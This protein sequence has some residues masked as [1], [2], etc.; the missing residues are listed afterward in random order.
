MAL[1]DPM[2]ILLVSL[3]FWLRYH[4]LPDFWARFPS[5]SP[6][7]FQAGTSIPMTSTPLPDSGPFMQLWWFAYVFN[8]DLHQLR[9]IQSLQLKVEVW[10]SCSLKKEKGKRI[11]QNIEHWLTLGFN[12]NIQGILTLAPNFML[13]L[14]EYLHAFLSDFL[15]FLTFHM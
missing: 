15:L 13:T 14:F 7:F 5:T 6:D 9:W 11:K 4:F 8:M 2:L 1:P 10:K 12:L 3:T